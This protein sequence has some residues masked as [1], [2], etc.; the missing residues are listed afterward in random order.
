MGVVMGEGMGRRGVVG[1]VMAAVVTVVVFG[2]GIMDVLVV[3]VTAL[4]GWS[5]SMG[6]VVLRPRNL[7]VSLTG[8]RGGSDSARSRR[9]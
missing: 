1:D 5:G 6:S 3:G 2:D 4:M 7:M 8:L 9:C